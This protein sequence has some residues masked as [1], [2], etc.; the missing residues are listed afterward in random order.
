[1]DSTRWGQLSRL[2]YKKPAHSLEHLIEL[3]CGHLSDRVKNEVLFDG[4]K[5]LRTNKARLIDLAPLTIAAI[6]RNGESI[7]VPA[8][9][10]L[11][12]NQVSA[13]KI[14]DHQSGAPLFAATISARKRNDDD[15]ACYRFDHAASSS[16]EFHSRPRT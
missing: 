12:K 5:P 15:F 9:G 4:E 13:G 11:A 8:A 2:V 16:G 10:D 14:G 6:Q 1:V 7:P 3:V